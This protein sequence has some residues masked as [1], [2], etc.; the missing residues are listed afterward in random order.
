MPR[1]CLQLSSTH[2][3][4]PEVLYSNSR[5]EE[6]VE[7]TEKAEIALPTTSMIAIRAFSSIRD[8]ERVVDYFLTADEAFLRGMG[9]DL[10]KLPDRESWLRRL[11]AD[12]E[13]DDREKEACFLAWVFN[14]KSVGHSNINNIKF[15][16]EAYLHLHLWRSDLRKAGLGTEFLRRS[17]ET[18]MDRFMLKRLV[19]EPSAENPAPNRALVKAGFKFIRKYRTV[20]SPIT[21]EQDVNRYELWSS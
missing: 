1:L 5:S 11:S 14:G 3:L 10:S 12:L 4:I 2:C 15:A 17:V 7:R 20:P 13:R 16:E 6:G 19:C 8:Y 18:F 9:V 21:S